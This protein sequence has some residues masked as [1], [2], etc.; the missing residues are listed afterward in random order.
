MD[1]KESI[2]SKLLFWA[3]ENFSYRE[4]CEDTYHA[5]SRLP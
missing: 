2:I 1:V 5:V 4:S 3:V